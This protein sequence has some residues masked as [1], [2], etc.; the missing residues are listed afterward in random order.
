MTLIR[1]PFFYISNVGGG[2]G[3][4]SVAIIFLDGPYI[5]KI[6]DRAIML[7]VGGATIGADWNIT[8]TSSGGGTP[9]TDFG[10]V[11]SSGFQIGPL[12]ISALGIGTLTVEYEE[13][14]VEVASDTE[15]LG[16][17]INVFSYPW[18]GV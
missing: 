14:A 12:D 17:T 18:L 3:T 10:V 13:E 6:T 16:E 2:G 15:T 5:D 9:V 1:S 8:I 11:A 7:E 4:V